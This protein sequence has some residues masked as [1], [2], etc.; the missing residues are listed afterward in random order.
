MMMVLV[1]MTTMM[2]AVQWPPK[3]TQ[4]DLIARSVMRPQTA[5]S[6]VC[7][8]KPRIAQSIKHKTDSPDHIHHKIHT[9][10]N[11]HTHMFDIPN[12][13]IQTSQHA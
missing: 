8:T 5:K 4:Q 13:P 11:T 10:S 7:A 3:E 1:M 9:D 2:M 6:V 12:T